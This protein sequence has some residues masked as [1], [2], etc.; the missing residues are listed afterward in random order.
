M[1]QRV[2]GKTGMR[3]SVLG[4]GGS[5]IG[6]ENAPQADV[7]R[8]LG[9]ALDAGLNVVDTAECYINSETLIGNAIGNRRDDYFLF[10]KCGHGARSGIDL[11]DFDPDLLRLQIDVSLKNLRTD[12][13]D[14]WQLHSCDE[15]TLRA[16][17]VIAVLQEAKAAGKARFIGYSGDN[18]ESRY[19]VECGAFDTL[20]T[21]VNIADQ[22]A[23]TYTIPLA[24]ERGMGVIAKRPIANAAWWSG[25][26][27]PASE[28]AR[29]Y[30][31]RLQVLKYE[32][33]TAQTREEIA[34]IALRFTLAVPGVSVAIVGTRNPGRWPE[35]AAVAS[36]GGLSPE[37]YHAIRLHWNGAAP[38]DWVT[39]R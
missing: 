14:L 24:Q 3:V 2:L 4:F 13:V 32:F 31:D 1:E 18:E 22:R 10:T 26:E 17:D 21:S 11:P 27:P 36:L 20:Q 25:T 29:Q 35:N 30:W 6:F 12:Y 8:L 16:G 23:T 38:A 15:A 34:G 19:A 5:E 28:Y 7:D 9:S 37:A 39:L 33:I